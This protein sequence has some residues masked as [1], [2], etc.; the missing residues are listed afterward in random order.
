MSKKKKPPEEKKKPA[1]PPVKQKALASES[2]KKPSQP[3]PVA[4]E[5]EIPE[6]EAAVP[7]KAA[8][9][10][11]M[12]PVVGIGASAGGLDAFKKFFQA[13]PSQSGM[14]FVLIPHLDPTHESLMV[15]LLRK[16]TPMP[17]VEAGE[18]MAVEA[19]YVY[20]IPPNKYLTISKG[21]LRL[22]GPVE[23]ARSSTSIDFFLRSLAEDLEE[24]A[25]CIIMSGT[26]AHGTL[27]LKAVK[28]YG[29]MA[30]VQ[31][32][33][34]AEY[35]RMP[36]SAVATQLADYVLPV[37]EMPAALIKYVQHF[38][39]N[40]GMVAVPVAEVPDQLHRILALLKARTNHD[41]HCY[42]KRMLVRRVERRMGL[43]H[44]E[45]LP[46]YLE[47]LRHNAEEVNRLVKDLLIS[48]TSFFRDPEAF[49]ALESHVLAPLVEAKGP[50]EAIRIWVPGCATGEEAYS[51]GM[52]L[53]EQ[54][55]RAQKS[56]RFQIF[57][58]DVDEDAMQAARHGLYP[59]SIVGDL[60][61]E[62][63]AKFFTKYDEQTYQVNKQLREAV[64]FAVQNLITDAPFSK[65]DL[66]S[67]RNLLIYLEPD[68]QQKV[69][70]LLH[71][72]L[73]EGGYLFL[74]PSETI[75]RQPD[76]FE[77][78]SKK[79]RIFKRIG[80][81]RMERLDFP[82]LPRE[83]QPARPVAESL[84]RPQANFTD[85]TQHLLLEQYAP[86]AVL[87]NR[88][89]EILYFFGP[90]R[91]YLEQPTGGPTQD[92]MLLTEG[93][94]RTKLRAAIH[95][96]V[97]DRE[98]VTAGDI[99]LKRNGNYHTV[100]ITVQPVKNPKGEELLL[101]T[102]ED[103]RRQPAVPAKK[104]ESGQ[105]E[106][107]VRQLEFELK[108]SRE[109]LQ[110]TIEELESSNEELKAAN[111]EVM[112]MN[113]ELQSANEEL[114]TSKEE[115]QSLNEELGTVNNQLQD[116]VGELEAA[117][118]DMANLL[119]SSDVATVFLNE[120]FRIS[121][122]TP[123]SKRFLNLIDRDLGRPLADIAVKF[124]DP[125]LVQDA[126][127]VLR[128]LTPLEK[129]LAG[130]DESWCIRRIIPY[131]TLDNRIH[132][133][134]LTFIDV[135]NLKRVQGDL[136]R[137]SKVFMEGADP[138][139]IHGLDG[140][141]TD[142]NFEVERVYGRSR[143]ELRGKPALTLVA[144]KFHESNSKLLDRCRQGEPIRN[145]ESL[146]ITKG[147]E[148]FPVLI[149]LSLLRSET[150]E[151]EGIATI[152]KVI[153]GIKETVEK[154]TK[155]L[156]LAERKILEIAGLE[157]RR[158]GQDLHDSLGQELTAL[159]LLADNL[160]HS[161][162]DKGPQTA[163]LDKIIAGLK[164]AQAQ[165][166]EL[167]QG[168]MPVD[169]DPEGLMAALRE[170]A[171]RS[172]SADVAC[173]FSCQQQ[174]LVDDNAAATHLFRIAQEAVHNALKHSKAKAIDINLAHK[175]GQ[176]TLQVKDNGVGIKKTDLEKA[177]LGLTSLRYRADLINARLDITSGDNGGTLVSCSVTA[178]G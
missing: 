43:N 110:S 173:R 101:V 13:M 32:P 161:L 79:W 84:P 50:E 148:E 133:V 71:Y 34:T 160:A 143:Q 158:I 93:G 174:V 3:P 88:R 98:K 105:D 102:F 42:R 18:G 16:Y 78:A 85:L 74:G 20:I 40:G 169:V 146:H 170:L 49:R 126:Q 123:A 26:G 139:F 70:S 108:T 162:T 149:T 31:D 83:R 106:S 113:E 138:I 155:E 25:I 72:S 153:T 75:G 29:G 10:R 39:I 89:N 142:C 132:G 167:S 103:D 80:A 141:I 60:S 115:L 87:I 38:Y 95:K 164:R 130:K 77:T 56:R 178:G 65:L 48:V 82:I 19:N 90:T 51:I 41:F 62:R 8:A 140:R 66:V 68:I 168:L 109:D 137:L 156:R 107:A 59:E 73:N 24:K 7:T 157:Q 163:A 4:V 171:K 129:E 100:C 86:A 135:T 53:M 54:I 150:G 61:A 145:A 112:S 114:E 21:V 151:P 17:V 22:T 35:S 9:D 177:G 44:I 131:R 63:L 176:I 144:P 67:C 122:F 64:V 23:R 28:A 6:L 36:E 57:A 81:A 175:D 111:E 116:K 30:V 152:A 121:R 69:I 94:L 5:T 120:D 165:V 37:E 119:N 46:A 47:H 14:A 2:K 99:Q 117:G 92:L 134:V 118:N 91:R 45:K 124:P 33:H 172:T 76:L 27:G 96:A 154:K 97:R 11:H 104:G 1:P 159:S 58:T 136:R 166:R 128:T 127:E 147:G 52:L 12:M 55:Q 15:E 125:N